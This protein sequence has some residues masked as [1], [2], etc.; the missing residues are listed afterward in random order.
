MNNY[1]MVDKIYRREDDKKGAKRSIPITVIYTL[2]LCVR[3]GI[4]GR[5]Y[6]GAHQSN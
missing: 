1:K 4:T 2:L 6:E 5:I 3:I